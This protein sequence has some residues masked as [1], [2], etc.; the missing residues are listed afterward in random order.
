MAATMS[1]RLLAINVTI[2][3]IMVVIITVGMSALLMALSSMVP[4]AG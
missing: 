4:T 2:A 3:I 1:T